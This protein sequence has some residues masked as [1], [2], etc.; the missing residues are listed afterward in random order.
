MVNDRVH[1]GIQYNPG[2]GVLYDTKFEEEIDRLYAFGGAV[3]AVTTDGAYSIC[4]MK[5]RNE[6]EG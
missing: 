6:T 2:F 3:R 1:Y 5:Q 4:K